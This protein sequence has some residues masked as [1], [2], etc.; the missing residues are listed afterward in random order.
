MIA[1][2]ILMACSN[3][4]VVIPSVALSFT[5]T[6]AP[7]LIPTATYTT[8]AISVPTPTLTPT[9]EALSSQFC[10]EAAAPW[11]CSCGNLSYELIQIKNASQAGL[12]N[13]TVP[14]DHHEVGGYNLALP[15]SWF[16]EVVGAA[17]NN[18]R[19]ISDKNQNII[20][21]SLIS[22]LPI[23]QADD[24][25]SIFQEGEGYWSDPVVATGEKKISRELVTI[26]DKQVLKLL[27]SQ[28]DSFILRYFMKSKDSLYVLKLE[29]RDPDNQESKKTIIMLEEAVQ[30]MRFLQ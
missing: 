30:S 11:S 13:I 2:A 19:C 29:M 26:G 8:T 16:C 18:L 25:I 20:L 17:S 28:N 9:V 27:T 1:S 14:L 12:C 23:T 7:I 5:A 21:Q 22:E 3:Q 15:D 10:M 6:S 24:A 4:K